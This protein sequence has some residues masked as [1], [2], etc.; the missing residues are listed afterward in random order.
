MDDFFLRCKQVR[1]FVDI[2]CNYNLLNIIF[3]TV[4]KYYISNTHIHMNTDYTCKGIKK[5][6]NAFLS[7][8]QRI[9]IQSSKYYKMVVLKKCKFESALLR[10]PKTV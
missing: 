7:L 1:Y 8:I 2:V 3:V 5:S 10:V 4:K 6:L 9:K